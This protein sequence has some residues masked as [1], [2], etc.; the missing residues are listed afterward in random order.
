MEHLAQ[1]RGSAADLPL[2]P[3]NRKHDKNVEVCM[4]QLR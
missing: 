4:P 2:F 3:D 1:S